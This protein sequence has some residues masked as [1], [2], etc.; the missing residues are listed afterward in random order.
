MVIRNVLIRNKLVLRNYFPWPIANLLH[1]DKEHLAL[2]NNSEEFP[3]VKFDCTKEIFNRKKQ[4][5]F[6]LGICILLHETKFSVLKP[7]QNKKGQKKFGVP[8]KKAVFYKEKDCFFL[9]YT[10]FFWP[11]LFW[12]GFISS[13]PSDSKTEVTLKP[14]LWPIPF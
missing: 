4:I 3:I 10:K 5:N 8:D 6:E 1:I 14:V 12:S 7:L 11:F 9:G 13:A 2:K